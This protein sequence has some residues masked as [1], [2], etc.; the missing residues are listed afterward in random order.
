MSHGDYGLK[1][2]N[3]PAP[4]FIMEKQAQK[5]ESVRDKLEGKIS[6]GIIM[7]L[8]EVIVAIR[9]ED[10]YNKDNKGKNISTIHT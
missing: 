10:K 5:L 8:N 4:Y 1:G 7:K 2:I 6:W 9:N 3:H